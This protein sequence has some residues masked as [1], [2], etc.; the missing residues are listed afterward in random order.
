MDVYHWLVAQGLWPSSV[1][2]LVYW[3]VPL[4]GVALI[5]RF[6]RSVVREA[7]QLWREHIAAQR[8]QEQHLERIAYSLRTFDSQPPRRYP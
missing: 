2:A 4:I 6:V 1:A 5:G 3:L 8:A 7:L